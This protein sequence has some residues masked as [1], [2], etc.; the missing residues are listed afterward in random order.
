MLNDYLNVLGYLIVGIS[1][2]ALLGLIRKISTDLTIVK[3][4]LGFIIFNIMAVGFTLIA[5]NEFFISQIRLSPQLFLIVIC[6][7]GFG[8]FVV[9][10]QW[11]RNL[12]YSRFQEYAEKLSDSSKE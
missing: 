2:L 3:L 10:A 12:S 5:M 1:G 9:I 6:F 4:G 11:L 8:V 7:G